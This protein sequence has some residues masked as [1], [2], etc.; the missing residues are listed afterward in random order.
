[1]ASM[2]CILY[3]VKE[4]VVRGCQIWA[5]CR[6]G[7]NGL[8]HFCDCVMCAQVGVRLSIVVKEENIFYFSV[9][10][11]SMNALSEFD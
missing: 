3:R 9:R 11:N 5:M 7:K 2:Q 4:V 10:M 6:M 8:S 1:M